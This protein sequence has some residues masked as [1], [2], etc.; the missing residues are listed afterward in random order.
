MGQDQGLQT[1]YFN[2]R[3]C[4][5]HGFWSYYAVRWSRSFTLR[6]K[7]SLSSSNYCHQAYTGQRPS[8]D[9]QREVEADTNP[10]GSD[11]D[12]DEDAGDDSDDSDG[13]NTII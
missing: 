6:C 11:S 5:A 1:S 9:T 12:E 4:L 8:G 13:G 3:C 10:W 7:F 2:S